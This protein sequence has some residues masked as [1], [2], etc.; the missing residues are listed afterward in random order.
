MDRSHNY[1]F[2]YYT[3][4]APNPVVIDFCGARYNAPYTEHRDDELTVVINAFS[5]P[6]YLPLI[7]EAVQ[8]QTR[9]PKQTW[10]VQN[11]PVGK[12][13]VPTTFLARMRERDDT[14]VIDSGLNHGCW[15]RFLL[16]ALHCRTRYLI[17]LDDDTMP[18][19]LAFS[20]VLEE[21]A[22]QPGLYGGRGLI[23]NDG[24]AGPQYWDHEVHGWHVGT[25]ETTQVDFAGHLW[26]METYWLHQLFRYLPEPYI[27]AR[28]QG[29]ECGEELFISYV[30]QR[31]G[32]N[33]YVYPHGLPYNARWSSVQGIEMGSHAAAMHLNQGLARADFYVRYFV[34]RG[35]KLI[36]HPRAQRVSLVS[37]S[38]RRSLQATLPT[39]KKQ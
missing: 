39:I 7:W 36:N 29:N 34:E 23:L 6:E 21:L 12:A 18:G 3:T 28:D 30:A 16:A 33:T 22:R 11:N 25:A 2:S 13:P 9:R 31:C 37:Q 10:I 38:A 14:V 5:R 15:F 20:T 26:A 4:V 1:I 19:R 32:L 27:K 35:W 8:Y 17:V 24:G